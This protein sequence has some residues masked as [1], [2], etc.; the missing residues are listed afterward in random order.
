MGMVAALVILTTL[1]CA[2]SDLI[3]ATPE[4]QIQ[5]VPVPRV[6]TVEAA[7]PPISLAGI[8]LNP[9]THSRTTILW[10]DGQFEVIGVIDTDD[11]EVFPVISSDWNGTRIRWSYYVPSTDY[12]VTFTMTSLAGDNLNCDWFNDHDASGTRTMERQDY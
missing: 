9:T 2:F 8:W 7:G 10:S 6:V 12:N 11:G 5:E 1:S 4:V 3:G